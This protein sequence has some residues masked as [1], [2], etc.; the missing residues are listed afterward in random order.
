MLDLK[1]I[2]NVR[3]LLAQCARD[4]NLDNIRTDSSWSEPSL[5][6]DLGVT[7]IRQHQSS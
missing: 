3:F 4:L 1:P 6:G 7:F 2:W 5:F